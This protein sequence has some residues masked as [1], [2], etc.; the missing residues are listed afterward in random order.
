MKLI[1]LLSKATF[2]N[3]FPKCVCTI[4]LS[5]YAC[6]FVHMHW[7]M[8]ANSWVIN[9]ACIHKFKAKQILSISS[10]IVI[11]NSIDSVIILSRKPLSWYDNH[12][13][14]SW[15]WVLTHSTSVI[16]ILF[17]PTALVIKASFIIF[18]TCLLSNLRSHFGMIQ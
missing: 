7:L 17:F 13:W 3:C 9:T 2:V 12:L 5:T 11:G 16:I 6:L 18:F 10:C 8:W 1:N 15:A 4:Y 14:L